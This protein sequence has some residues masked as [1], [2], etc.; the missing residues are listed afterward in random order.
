MARAICRGLAVAALVFLLNTRA[1]SYGWCAPPY[2]VHYYPVYRVAYYYPATCWPVPVYCPPV[3]PIAAYPVPS[4]YAQPRPAPPS[5]TPEP[6]L[7]KSEQR[8][9]KVSESRYGSNKADTAE[10][11][12]VGFWNLTGRDVTLLIEGQKHTLP[13]NRAITL[14]LTRKFTWRLDDGDMRTENVP[15]DQGTFEVLLRG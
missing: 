8:A 6:P 3:V 12:R 13:R 15:R 1:Q 10:K 2:A 9:P 14:T 7:E 11:L 4:P 5:G